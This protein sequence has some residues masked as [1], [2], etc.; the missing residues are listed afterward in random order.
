MA[1]N[2]QDNLAYDL[3]LF[4]EKKESPAKKED[5]KA[6][7]GVFR[8]RNTAKMLKILAAVVL[9]GF[10]AGA[11][12]YSNA[13]LAELDSKALSLQKELD[14][15]EDE[16][17]RLNIELDSRV[18]M[19]GM[20]EYITGELGMVKLEKYQV[21]YVNLSEGDT[22]ELAEEDGGLWSDITSFF[23]GIKEYFG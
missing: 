18:C 23:A 21:N 16:E 12:L 8:K 3:S 11:L 13:T 6:Q 2:Y 1:P 9:C 19:K 15:L 5:E 14:R 22:M 10:L 17:M 4:E 20:D 7:Q